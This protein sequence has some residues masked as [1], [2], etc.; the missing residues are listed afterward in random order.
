MRLQFKWL[1]GAHPRNYFT[2][3]LRSPDR[4]GICLLRAAFQAV[5]VA[6][7]FDTDR[8]DPIERIAVT[9]LKVKDNKSYQWHCFAALCWTIRM[10]V[11]M[12]A[13][14]TADAE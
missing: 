8:L 5:E 6:A 9:A 14:R 13:R 7:R 3:R 4:S 2:P 12:N 1:I 11:R 10:Q